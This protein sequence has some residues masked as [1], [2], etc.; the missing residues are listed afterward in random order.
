MTVSDTKFSL[1]SNGNDT[2]KIE[3]K[4]GG[5]LTT[6]NTAK[7]QYCLRLGGSSCS[8]KEASS[9]AAT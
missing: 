6:N 9:A 5:H 2:T 3:V 7:Q 8:T 1:A 4:S